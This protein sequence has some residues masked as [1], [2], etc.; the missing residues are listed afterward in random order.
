MTL[1][2]PFQK[3]TKYSHTMY[4]IAVCEKGKNLKGTDLEL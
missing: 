2:K 1:N 4:S 3:P